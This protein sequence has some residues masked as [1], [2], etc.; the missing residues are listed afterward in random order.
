MGSLGRALYPSLFFAFAAIVMNNGSIAILAIIGIVLS[1]VVSVGLTNRR[2]NSTNNRSGIRTKMVSEPIRNRITMPLIML[3]V[4]AFVSSFATQGIAAWIP[5]YLALQ[6]GLGISGTLGIALTGM[7]AAAIVGQPV[8]GYL[9][10][11]Y[12]K[13]LVLAISILGSALSI[14]GYLFATGDLDYVLLV[15]LGLFTFSG[16]PIFL[17]LASDYVPKRASSLSNALVWS[18][19]VNGGGVGGPAVVGAIALSGYVSWTFAFGMMAAAALISA[20]IIPL[21]GKP[22]KPSKMV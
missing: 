16:Y 22:L 9:V 18:L 3:T 4:V 20:A 6:K 2:D 7:Y 10:D 17:S 11:R 12:D 5:T 1:V 13:R 21:L 8:F 14:I 15:L 19:G